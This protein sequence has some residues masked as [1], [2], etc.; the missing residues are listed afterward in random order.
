MVTQGY[1]QET[2]A[3]RRDGQSG[4]RKEKP[5]HRGDGQSGAYTGDT[6]T[7]GRWL[8]RGVHRR[9]LHTGEMVSDGVVRRNLYT[10]EM[11]TQGRTQKTPAHR[12]DGYSGAHTEDT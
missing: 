1:T 9:H 7:Q 5:A 3:H 12:R 8:L 11:V 10:G 4:C 2:P 6:F